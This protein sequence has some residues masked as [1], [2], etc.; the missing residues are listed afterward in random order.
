MNVEMECLICGDHEICD[1][2][3]ITICHGCQNG[4]MKFMPKEEWD[5]V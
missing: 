4:V 2:D 5:D 3:K 1:T